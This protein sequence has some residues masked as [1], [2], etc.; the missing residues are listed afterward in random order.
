MAME[1][2]YAQNVGYSSVTTVSF[3]NPFDFLKIRNEGPNSVRIEVGEDISSSSYVIPAETDDNFPVRGK[4]VKLQTL[5][6]GET[7]NVRLSGL[8]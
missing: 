5:N 8:R 6:S 2:K 7:A 1:N 4:E 3:T